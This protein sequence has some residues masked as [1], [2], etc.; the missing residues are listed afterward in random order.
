LID[1]IEKTN[2]GGTYR[3]LFHEKKMELIDNMLNNLDATLDET[4]AWGGA[5]FITDT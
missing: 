4:G 1:I 5:M 2:T 3:F